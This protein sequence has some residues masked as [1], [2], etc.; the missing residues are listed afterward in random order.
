[1]KYNTFKLYSLNKSN[2]IDKTNIYINKFSDFSENNNDNSQLHNINI[3]N[4]DTIENV[5]YK[6]LSV[7][8]DKNINNYYFFYKVK[9]KV[10]IREITKDLITKEELIILLNNFNI[11]DVTLPENK[12]EFTINELSS[13][14]NDDIEYEI[15][16]CFNFNIDYKKYIIN[17]L[18]NNYNYQ[19]V[20]IKSL[21]SNL[22]F[23]YDDIVDNTI[24]SLYIGDYLDYLKDNKSLTAKSTMNIYYNVL[25]SKDLFTLDEIYNNNSDLYDKLYDKYDKYNKLIDIHNEFYFNN[26][27]KMSQFK[28]IIFLQDVEFV[29]YTKEEILFPLEIFFKKIK[30]NLE[31]PI[32]K[33]NP[34]FK[35]E[36]IYKLYSDKYDLH[37]NKIPYISK[38][39]A[40]YFKENMKKNKSVSLNIIFDEDIE[41]MIDINEYGHIYCNLKQLK[42]KYDDINT[43]NNYCKKIIDTIIN[44]F[45][46]LFDPT[47][48]VYNYF[49]NI[50]QDNIKILDLKYLFNC[51][52]IS[53]LDY[54]AYKYFPGVIAINKEKDNLVEYNYKRVSY[55]NKMTDIDSVITKLFKKQ[56]DIK[57]IIDKCSND[58]YQNNYEKAEEYVT[59]FISSIQVDDHLKTDG[60]STRIVN[61]EN[62]PGISIELIN[63]NKNILF[64]VKNINHFSYIDYF[65]VYFFN[66]MSILFNYHE[67]SELNRVFNIIKSEN[68]TNIEIEINKNEVINTDDRK[69]NIQYN[70]TN[71]EY[72][73]NDE[74]L[75]ESDNDESFNNKNVKNNKGVKSVNEESNNER[76]NDSIG[77]AV[78]P[79]YKNNGSPIGIEET[80]VGNRD[81]Y[82][83][84]KDTSQLSKQNEIEEAV[85]E[86]D[87]PPQNE[88]KEASVEQQDTT[89]NEIEEASV[90]QQDTPQNESKE[91]SVEQQDTPQNES[92]KASVEQ[93]D[94]PQNESENASVEQQDT[95]QNESKEASVEKDS[96][97][98]ESEEASVEQDSPEVSVEKQ[99]NN[100]RNLKN[101][102][103]NLNSLSDSE[104]EQSGGGPKNKYTLSYPN[105]FQNKLQ[106]LQPLLFKV[107][108]KSKYKAYSRMCPWTDRRQP[109]ILSQKDKEHIDKNF[110]GTYDDIVEY[111]TNPLNEKFYYICPKY[112]NIKDDAPVKEENVNKNKLIDPKAT[113]TDLDDKYIFQFT[114]DSGKKIRKQIPGFLQKGTKVNE[115][116]FYVPCCFGLKDGEAQKKMIKEAENQMKKI[117]ESELTNQDDVIEFIKSGVGDR[118]VVKEVQAFYILDQF[119]FP[120]PQGRIGLLPFTIE[121]FFGQSNKK[122]NPPEK[123]PCLM[124]YGV[125][126]NEKKSFLTCLTY[127]FYT[128]QELSD[129]KSRNIS[130]IDSIIERIKNTINIDNILQFHNSN[131]PK[132]FYKESELD[133]VNLDKYKDYDIYK[134]LINLTKNNK[135]LKIIINGYENFIKYIEDPKEI[136][137]YYYLWDIVC[138]G[139][140]N[141]NSLNKHINMIIIKENNDD[142]T[143]NISIICPVASYSKYLFNSTKKTIILYNK[144]DT[145]EP[146]VNMNTL[147]EGKIEKRRINK[148]TEIDENHFLYETLMRINDNISEKCELEIN[149]KLYEFQENIDIHSLILNYNSLLKN[150]KI[151]YQVLNY[152]NKTI[153]IYVQENDIEF[154][155][156]LNPSSIIKDI[157]YK[158]INDTMWID[159]TNTKSMLTKFYNDTKG[160]VN[161]LPKF[162]IVNDEFI[163][164]ILTNGNQ[165]VKIVN[166]EDNINDD[167]PIKYDYDLFEIEK[168]IH[169]NIDIIDKDRNKLIHY[170][171]LEKKFYTTFV[172]TIKYVIYKDDDV[173]NVRNIINSNSETV[174]KDKYDE[175]YNIIENITDNYVEFIDFDDES[176]LLDLFDINLCFIENNNDYCKLKDDNNVLL[177]PKNNLYNNEDNKTKYISS[178]V[179]DLLFNEIIK[180]QFINESH[181]IIN[182]DSTYVSNDNEI[183]LLEKKLME[184][185]NKLQKPQSNYILQ[186]VYENIEPEYM[187][188]MINYKIY[189]KNDKLK[190]QDE[191]NKKSEKS[192][193]NKLS[194][195][196]KESGVEEQEE[197]SETKDEVPEIEEE[198][199]EAEKEVP[200]A[201]EEVPEAEKEVPKAEEEV[202]EAE[203]EVPE[204]E[205]E[206]PEVEEEVPEAEVEAEAEEEDEVTEFEQQEEAETKK[207]KELLEAEEEEE[208]VT[209][210]EPQEEAPEAEEE[211]EEET[212]EKINSIM[213]EYNTIKK[214]IES[215]SRSKNNISDKN[216][217]EIEL[218][219]LPENND[220]IIKLPRK[221]DKIKIKLKKKQEKEENVENLDEETIERRLNIYKKIKFDDCVDIKFL[222]KIWRSHFPEKTVF[223]SFNKSFKKCNYN[224]LIYILKSYNINAYNKVTIDNIKDM[225]I[226]F[227]KN[228]AVPKYYSNI[229]NIWKKENKGNYNLIETSIENIIKDENYLLT[230]ID[231]LLIS[232]NLKIPIVVFFESKKKIKLI[233]FT[234]N[235][236]NKIYYFIKA[237]SRSDNMYLTSNKKSLRFN[238]DTLSSNLQDALLENKY[239]NFEDY[240]V[241]N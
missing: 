189:S 119:K 66:F 157:E 16:K 120:I 223:F 185:Y 230:A 59:N 150:Y 166:I 217:N 74:Y 64:E 212:E 238:F 68:I 121:K 198:V 167:L 57:Y 228:Y 125:E 45:I 137:T 229:H 122:C 153:G 78:S 3:Y 24:Y 172:N 241:S 224:L 218:S 13:Y 236:T 187:I 27:T 240:L 93:Q 8:S 118:K 56:T 156:P 47:S 42:Y 12:D 239:N 88:S 67:L 53:K 219:K 133:N 20:N 25:T 10:N 231:L 127:L 18:K 99:S 41:I 96:P 43:L 193:E 32:I 209:E 190:S 71:E 205:E 154:F 5:L 130:H 69:L 151:L 54:E 51:G 158:L 170:L 210:F 100:S 237:V 111:G 114:K 38:K 135:Q 129:L 87:T 63:N 136:I 131:I 77:H 149:N 79:K 26:Y 101:N 148:I 232:D 107:D 90:E 9:K 222:T 162:K 116:G 194:K 39:K 211:A 6:L 44:Y 160:I 23:E 92:E 40:K 15:D 21:L 70:S 173:E 89:Q 196:N 197:E 143:N 200:K 58:F 52:N 31:L 182:L 124:R 183:I 152:D 46:K 106:K 188:N 226:K 113:E 208:E 62:N 171:K 80:K 163:V 37:G 103:F 145:F 155:V 34:G 138:S 49:N 164:G 146:L 83:K 168:N 95:P 82:D 235:N 227:Y 203:E 221:T 174:S 14:I 180:N 220:L 161:C 102:N 204:A 147:K 1:M 176:V 179:Y 48:S 110:P 207:E 11:S 35:I 191:D 233:N 225:L 36:N 73:N 177:I 98:I 86:K 214:S 186:T 140:L 201:E 76:S 115:H 123:E 184:Y 175:L 97:Q 94:T 7:L 4:D 85:V 22:L 178:L 199:F 28:D 55:Y 206:V 108:S 215:K 169:E 29:Y 165:F 75:I 60:Q 50:L 144:N 17:P 19:N 30:C 61:I 33:Y 216:Y 159:Y 234:K 105:P 134:K 109:I 84:N 195:T 181:N 65:N 142:I 91:A 72:S 81:L 112:W 139:I 104:D 126:S 213:N 2:N 202:P 117:E 192:D 128:N 132:L 141:S